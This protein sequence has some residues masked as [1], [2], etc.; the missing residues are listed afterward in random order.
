MRSPDPGVVGDDSQRRSLQVLS[1]G[2]DFRRKA[3]PVCNLPQDIGPVSS[4]ACTQVAAGRELLLGKEGLPKSATTLPCSRCSLAPRCTQ[5][6]QA[7]G[8]GGR[9]IQ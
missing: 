5:N 8:G 6:C 9:D 7:G 2:K 3:N 4:L 1:A